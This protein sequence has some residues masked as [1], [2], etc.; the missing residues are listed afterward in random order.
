MG[1]RSSTAVPIGLRNNGGQSSTRKKATP[2]AT[3]KAKSNASA[4][5]ISVP[6]IGPAAP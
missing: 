4:E 1:C 2:P 3:G 6:T 5:V